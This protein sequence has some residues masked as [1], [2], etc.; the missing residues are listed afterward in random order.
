MELL[1]KEPYLISGILN[2]LQPCIVETYEDLYLKQSWVS[3][4][5]CIADS[6]PPC[7]HK[8]PQKTTAPSMHRIQWHF[9]KQGDS[10]HEEAIN[11]P[12]QN[13]EEWEESWPQLLCIPEN[14]VQLPACKT[15]LHFQLVKICK[16]FDGCQ[17]EKG[18]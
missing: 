18:C 4:Q 8:T 1:W 12:W 9:W 15:A 14:S 6:Y 3:L 11:L 10:L 13:R 7:K 16:L 17:E 5:S 2:P